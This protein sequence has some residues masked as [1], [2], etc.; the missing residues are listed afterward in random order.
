MSGLLLALVTVIILTAQSALSPGK[1]M[2]VALW[3]IKLV[4]SIWLVQY[5]IKEFSKSFEIFTYKDG[6]SYGFFVCLFSSFICAI[7]QF[8]LMA[9]IF[10]EALEVQIEVIISTL[11]SSNPAAVD[12][13]LAMRDSL[14][15]L[16]AVVS[17][18]WYTIFG[19][20]V[21]SIVANFTK[22]GNQIF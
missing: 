5:F 21:S 14:P 9:V 19:L 12:R 18:A 22:K 8:L 17:F 6:F 7:T 20:I 10:P 11:E 15:Y 1:A 2:N 13:F 3:V 16:I 4:A